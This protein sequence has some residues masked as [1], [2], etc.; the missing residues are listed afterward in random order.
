MMSFLAD[1]LCFPSL[2][3]VSS[4]LIVS[5][6]G[7][8]S[9][10]RLVMYTILLSGEDCRPVG[11]LPAVSLFLSELVFRSITDI[12]EENEL[13]TNKLCSSLLSPIPAGPFPVFRASFT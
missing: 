1:I 9:V 3:I 10:R 5:S 6:K 2:R 8:D 11:L 12:S 7:F 4:H 13:T